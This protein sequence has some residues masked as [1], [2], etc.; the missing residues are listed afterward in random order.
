MKKMIRLFALLIC[1]LCFSFVACQKP[2]D[3]EIPQNPN[4][5]Q[6]PKQEETVD[7]PPSIDDD[8]GD[9]E[10]ENTDNWWEGNFEKPDSPENPSNPDEP[11]DPDVPVDPDEPVDPDTPVD[12]DEPSEPSEPENPE[13]GDFDFETKPY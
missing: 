8:L 5:N 13:D 9:F 1:V 7:P 12:P 11:V 3:S 10:N 6:P 2:D 4:E